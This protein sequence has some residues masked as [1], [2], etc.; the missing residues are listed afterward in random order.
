MTARLALDTSTRVGSAAVG[1]G[2]R[3]LAEVNL[4][5]EGIHS[6]VVMPAVDF[7]LTVAGVAPHEIREVVV[8]A[9]PG[10]FTGVRTAVS[11]A[12]GWCTGA[13]ATLY[14]YPSLL[15]LAA[16][17]SADGQPI[18]ALL[19]ARRGEVY[20]ACYEFRGDEVRE[21]LAPAAF[22][23]PELV[24]RSKDLKKSARWVGDG[25]GA[26]RTQ[27]EELGVQVAP[28][29]PAWPRAS[30]LLW[31]RARWPDL[32]RVRDPNTWEPLYVRDAGV[33]PRQFAQ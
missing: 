30:A 15:A 4:D 10:S 18:C 31:L 6:Q 19:D 25:A 23:I 13:G 21:V 12:K 9:G 3:A 17:V 32:G 28:G 7:A 11:I 16:S 26:Y 27:L 8:G 24:E 29:P 14:G 33:R 20:A 5:I 2:D 1:R 22:T